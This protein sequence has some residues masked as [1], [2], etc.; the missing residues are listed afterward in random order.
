MSR[1]VIP[2]RT[3]TATAPLVPPQL[4]GDPGR[5]LGLLQALERAVNAELGAPVPAGAWL[6]ELRVDDGEAVL[7]L[8]PEAGRPELLQLAFETL[9]GLLVDTDIYVGAAAH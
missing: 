2:I 8:T 6:R 5:V 3:A 1:R 4:I 9:R 7:A